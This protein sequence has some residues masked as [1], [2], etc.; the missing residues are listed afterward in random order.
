MGLSHGNQAM[1]LHGYLTMRN[2]P[3]ADT[4]T[5]DKTGLTIA[6]NKATALYYGSVTDPSGN[7]LPG[8]WMFAED[9]I[10]VNSFVNAGEGVTDINGNYVMAAIGGGNTWQLGVDNSLYFPVYSFSSGEQPTIGT[11]QAVEFDVTA[12]PTLPVITASAFAG[13]GH[14]QVAASGLTSVNYTLEMSTNLGS[15]SWTP[16]L[17]TNLAGSTFRFTDTAATNMQR[18]YRILIGP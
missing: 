18:F 14:F 9:N 17:V 3:S 15:T 11:G 5:G 7:P 13:G 8:V 1:M 10:D 12:T 6:L 2:N 16:L 4:T